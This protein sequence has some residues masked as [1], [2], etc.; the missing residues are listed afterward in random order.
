MLQVYEGYV[1]LRRASAIG[2]THHV[3]GVLKIALGKGAHHVQLYLPSPS[4]V[5]V[6]ARAVGLRETYPRYRVV[7]KHCL[8]PL[9]LLQ[10]K[11][12]WRI[13][14]PTKDSLGVEA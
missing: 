2:N 1:P 9:K 4:W 8:P 6:C 3:G 12:G 7:L 10:N 14:E 5:G 13:A 11:I